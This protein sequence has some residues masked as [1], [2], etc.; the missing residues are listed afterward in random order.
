MITTTLL[1]LLGVMIWASTFAAY[2]FICYAFT[3]QTFSLPLLPMFGLLLL[4]LTWPWPT[5]RVACLVLDTLTILLAGFWRLK[6][7]LADRSSSM[8]ESLPP[9]GE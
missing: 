1:I 8:N 7:L 2:L 5:G 6:E 9:D 4:H 3:K